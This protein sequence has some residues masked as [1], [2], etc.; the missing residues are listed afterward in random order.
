[1][2][3]ALLILAAI[4]FATVL[5]VAFRVTDSLA[6]RGIRYLS[7]RKRREPVRVVLPQLAVATAYRRER[8]ERI[9]MP[10]LTK[11]QV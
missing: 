5:V 8:R 10:A 7:A 11:G 9:K 1:M 3:N 6:D 4:G 2:I